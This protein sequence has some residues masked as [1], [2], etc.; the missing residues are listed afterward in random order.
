MDI[1]VSHCTVVTWKSVRKKCT[2]DKSSDNYARPH[3]P[4]ASWRR[5]RVREGWCGVAQKEL[6]GN[7]SLTYCQPHWVTSGQSNSIICRCTFLISKPF[8]KS[9]PQNQS[10]HKHKTCI[11]KT[12]HW[13]LPTRERNGCMSKGGKKREH[14]E[15]RGSGLVTDGVGA[16]HVQGGAAPSACGIT[17]PTHPAAT[18]TKCQPLQNY[19]L[20]TLFPCH[21]HSK[22]KTGLHQPSV[23]KENCC[24]PCALGHSQDCSEHCIRR[25]NGW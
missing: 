25:W 13:P 8:L 2:A 3:H 16:V 23:H 19:T 12:F 11:P 15:S 5:G 18:T 4:C 9:T 14:T 7:W 22:E 6:V 20:T 10:L 17:P 21:T 24:P 1:P